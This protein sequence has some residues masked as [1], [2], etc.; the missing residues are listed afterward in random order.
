MFLNGYPDDI[1]LLLM[2]YIFIVIFCR[3]YEIR[4]QVEEEILLCVVIY[5]V[6]VLCALCL[7]INIIL[8]SINLMKIDITLLLRYIKGLLKRLTFLC[9]LCTI[10][11]Q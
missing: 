6:H 9:Y 1:N 2:F 11:M 10:Q 7:Y 4:L 8:L 3:K 5:Y